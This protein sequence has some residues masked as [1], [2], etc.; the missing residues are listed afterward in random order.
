MPLLSTVPALQ[1]GAALCDPREVAGQTSSTSDG[2][3]THFAQ[4]LFAQ[5]PDRYDRLAE[6]LSF[7][8]NGRWRKEMVA[9]AVADA[10]GLVLDVATGPAGVARQLAKRSK[11]TVVGID[12]TASMLRAA[13]SLVAADGLSERITLV[14][15][16]GEQLPF[17]DDCFDALTF[18]YLLRYV[19]DPA[20]VLSELARVVRPGGAIASLEFCVPPSPAWH[21]AWVGY[22]R[23]VLPVA[24]ALTGGREWY[25]VGRF[26]G[27]SISKHYARY[28]IAWTERAW[29]DAGITDVHSKQMSLGGGLVMWGRKSGG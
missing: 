7:G 26:L 16:T 17:P 1:R 11:A 14:R 10:P 9:H 12:I 2:R 20:A 29:Q 19:P 23:L 28:P 13:S 6:W 22:T 27:P 24:G 21:A 8:Q 15:G 3:S 25:E 5:L 18:T 4:G